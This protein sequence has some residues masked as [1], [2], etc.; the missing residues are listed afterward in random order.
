MLWV[1]R[2]DRDYYGP[3]VTVVRARSREEA[4]RL[5]LENYEDYTSLE[6]RNGVWYVNV[7]NSGWEK[8][9][10]DSR[11][12]ERLTKYVAGDDHDI[13]IIPLE[14]EGDDGVL[15][16]RCNPEPPSR[17]APKRPEVT[18]EGIA[19]DSPPTLRSPQI[20]VVYSNTIASALE[21]SGSSK[22]RNPDN[23]K[24]TVGLLDAELALAKAKR[25]HSG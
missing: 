4:V 17:P 21:Q 5:W 12:F 15:V 18:M 19:C 11:L 7:F 22:L 10:E 1:I 13:Q 9:S 2:D 8:L 25:C 3:D 16:D 14:P 24:H 6:K 23:L 20:R